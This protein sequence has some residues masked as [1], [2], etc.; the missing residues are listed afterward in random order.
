M[1][2]IGDQ[3]KNRGVKEFTDLL[4]NFSG[5]PGFCLEIGDG[6]W[7]SWFLPLEKQTEIVCDKVKEM[8]EL[9]N[10]YNIVGL[11][12]GNL[13]GR[14]VLE[15]CEGAPPVKNFIS[16][17]GPHAGTASVPLCGSGI[18]CIIADNLIKGEIY[19]DFI[20]DHLAPAGYLKLP[21]DIPH[22]LD[23]CKF[24]PKLN[25]E[26]PDERNSTYKERFTSLENLVLIM[27]EDDNVLIPKETSWFGYY[28][29]GSFK[30]I[31]PVQQTKLYVEDW[32]GLKT[33]DEA[34]RVHFVNVS[35][36]HLGI[37]RSDMEKHV[38]PFLVDSKA[39]LHA[40]PRKIVPKHQKEQ[41]AD[42]LS[43]TTSSKT[44]RISDGSSSFQWPLSVKGFLREL[45]GLRGE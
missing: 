6:T 4:T 26:I 21:N 11:S 10:G 17:G 24:L 9:S 20:Q 25:N 3:C 22:Y 15:F 32:I 28:P 43:D 34:G 19:S 5:S 36:G 29:D 14:G 38:V 16:L 27:S 2:G 41:V 39:R 35:G 12:Q 13:I 44:E 42:R 40:L 7:D 30:T 18:F 1:P 23:K 45:V 8:K 37:S 31:L 33:L